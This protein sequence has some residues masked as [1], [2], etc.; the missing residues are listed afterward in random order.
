LCIVHCALCIMHYELCIEKNMFLSTRN[1]K[2][3]V[4][5]SQAIIKGLADDGGLFV[6]HEFPVLTGDDFVALLDMDYAARASFVMGKLFVELK[7]FLPDFTKTAYSKFEEDDGAPLVKLDEKLYFLELWHGPT[8]AFKDIALT[9]LPSLLAKSKELVGDKSK[10][11]IL[12]ATSGDTGKAALEGF[13]EDIKSSCDADCVRHAAASRDLSSSST[14]PHAACCPP[15]TAFSTLSTN[16]SKEKTFKHGGIDVVVLYPTD[17]VSNLQKLQMQTTTGGNVKVLAIRGNFD[18]AQ[19]S[20]KEIFGDKNVAEKLAK[21]NINLSSANSIN[22][23]R[24]VPQIAYY[25]SAY[26]DMVD[27][28][29]ISHGDKINFCV[30]TGNFGNILAGYYAKKMGLPINKLICA[31]NKNNV[32]TDFFNTGTYSLKREFYKTTSPSMDILISSNLERLIFEFSNRD[33]KLTASRIADLKIKGSYSVSDK[34]LKEL[35]KE[36]TADFSSEEEVDKTID[37][38]FEEYGYIIDP[39]TAVAL[40]VYN[41]YKLAQKDKTP[42]VIVSTASP[43]KFTAD[44]L[45]AIG[46]TPT[47]NDKKDIFLLEDLTALPVPETLADL[48]KMPILHKEVLDKGQIV[49]AIFKRYISV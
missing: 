48:F 29:T 28:G 12:V 4:T 14:H 16:A 6:P 26:A 44:V 31:S 45:T 15:D 13:K 3:S 20:V 25:F 18:D 22:I 38:T 49:N 23:G 42:T 30:P 1:K 17:G 32:L 7:E 43:Y 39:H 11:L 21:N 27:S 46:E 5:A 36:F 41:K 24:L 19:S 9:I 47:G 33:D 37:D 34:E 10:T 40:S 2:K 8:Y 35:Q